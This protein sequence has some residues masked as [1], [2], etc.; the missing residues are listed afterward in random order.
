MMSSFANTFIYTPKTMFLKI[1]SKLG[2]ML[3]MDNVS[4]N[5]DNGPKLKKVTREMAH[6]IL[7]L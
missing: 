2:K 7:N 4:D 3:G 6:I 1:V 5:Y